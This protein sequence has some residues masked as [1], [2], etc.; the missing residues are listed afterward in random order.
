MRTALA[1]PIL[2]SLV[3][4]NV[5]AGEMTCEAVESV[6]AQTIADRLKIIVVDNGSRDGS[7]ALLRER[8][9]GRITLIESPSNLGFAGGNNLAF[10][11]AEGKYLL[12]LNNDAVAV[13]NWA[14][15]LISAAEAND[16]AMCTSKIV[17]YD[18][19]ALIDCVGHNIYPDGLSRS[20]GNWRRD[21]GQYDRME[22][23][24][25]ASG[26]AALY[27]RQAVE[28]WGGF[29]EKFF[30]YQE[31]VDLGLKLRLAGHKCLYV[32]EALVYHHGSRTEEQNPFPKVFL[33][34][35]NRVWVMLQ[36][37]PWDWILASPWHTARRLLSA[38]RAASRG[39]GRIGRYAQSR[40]VG[41]LGWVV[42]R[43][44][45]GALA[46]APRALAQRRHILRRRR[47][48]NR[49]FKRLLR[50]FRA[51]LSEMAFV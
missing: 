23:T 4:L 34:E 31:D 39:E 43:A 10:R 6:L 13:P 40:A 35:R 36:F 45:C 37:F 27:L 28:E 33:I 42:L 15:A 17:T 2:A 38:W 44:W 21:E 11:Q 51:P 25:Y 5:N 22:E 48:G 8:F 12:L 26:C 30:A 29:D 14:E 3:M 50:R 9:G 47:I 24:L 16:A 7:P 20:R 46:G 1:E 49:E 32:P 19:H 18:D 41:G